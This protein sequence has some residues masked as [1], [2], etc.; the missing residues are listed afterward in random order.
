MEQSFWDDDAL[1][2]LTCDGK[3]FQKRETHV[4]MAEA[5]R[6]EPFTHGKQ[7]HIDV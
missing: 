7:R 2:L 3:R 6:N 5:D 1:F 4:F